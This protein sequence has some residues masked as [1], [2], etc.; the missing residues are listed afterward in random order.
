MPLQ[1]RLPKIGFSNPNRVV[2]Q[3]VNL[4]EIARRELSGEV[5]PQVLKDA[6][7]IKSLR[8]PV[9]V[10]GRGEISAAV[11]V[12]A[13]AFSDTASEKITRAGGS[14]EVIARDASKPETE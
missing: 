1:R 8:R 9:K 2:Y 6:G 12:Q 4:D 7:L 13:H 10:L 3:V 5:T 11:Q 14:V